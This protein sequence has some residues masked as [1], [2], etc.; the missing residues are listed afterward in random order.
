ML[1]EE[2]ERDGEATAQEAGNVHA[3][4]RRHMRERYLIN[5]MSGFRDH[6]L[7]ELLLYYAIPR[8]DTNPIGHRLIERYG[9]LYNVFHAPL[10]DLKRVEGIGESAAI[11]L[12]LTAQIMERAE[13]TAKK[14]EVIIRSSAEAGAYLLRCFAGKKNEAIY[15]LCIDKKGKLLLGKWLGEGGI[16]SAGLNIRSMVENALLSTSSVVILAHNHPSGLALPSSE[17]YAATEQARAALDMVGIHLADH[18]IIADGDY[19]SL[20]DSGYLERQ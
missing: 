20:A 2:Y 8:R 3:N 17:D 9:S 19:V 18:I 6:E 13:A 11:L 4:H 7:L 5:E 16:T 1:E 10:E 14:Q 12:R 15:Q